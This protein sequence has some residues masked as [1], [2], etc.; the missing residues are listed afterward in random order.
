MSNVLEILLE[1]KVVQESIGEK[2]DALIKKLKADDPTLNENEMHKT[3]YQRIYADI[4]KSENLEADDALWKIR[5]LASVSED[6]L[7]SIEKHLLKNQVESRIIK[8]VMEN[9]R[10]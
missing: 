10:K 7:L 8:Q 1:S 3:I 5:Q 2:I 6:K 4:H 9:L